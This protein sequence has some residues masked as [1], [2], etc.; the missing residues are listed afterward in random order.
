MKHHHHVRR[1]GSAESRMTKDG[2]KIWSGSW[3]EG[4]RRRLPFILI[5]ASST[6]FLLLFGMYM[7]KKK[8]CVG[9]CCHQPATKGLFRLT[10]KGFASPLFIQVRVT[11]VKTSSLLLKINFWLNFPQDFIFTLVFLHLLKSLNFQ[12]PREIKI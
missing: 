11:T 4:G 7:F 9:K 6:L 10:M 2:N 3:N 1:F 12:K 8:P 5:L